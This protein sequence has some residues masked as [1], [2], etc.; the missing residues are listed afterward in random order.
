MTTPL[1]SL[2]PL[3]QGDFLF[4]IFHFLLEESALIGVNQCLKIKIRVNPRN[5]WLRISV[6]NK[7]KK[8]CKMIIYGYNM[9]NCKE[10]EECKCRAGIDLCRQSKKGKFVR[11]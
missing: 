6:A 11:C 4:S 7:R 3:W 2:W 5:P 1:C 9:I 8:P 10:M